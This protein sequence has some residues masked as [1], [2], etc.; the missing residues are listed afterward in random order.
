[1]FYLLL[2]RDDSPWNEGEGP[3]SSNDFNLP[4]AILNALVPDAG[5]RAS[6]TTSQKSPSEFND[7]FKSREAFE[8]ALDSLKNSSDPSVAAIPE[9]WRRIFHPKGTAYSH[10]SDVNLNTVLANRQAKPAAPP[11]PPPAPAPGTSPEQPLAP[12]PPKCHGV[13]GD[14]WMLSGDQAVSASEQFC[15]QDVKDKE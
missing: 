12:Q 2:T 9:Q 10:H 7:A 11:P 5:Q 14:T 4:Q 6:I 13:S 8:A 15:K 1:M 3:T